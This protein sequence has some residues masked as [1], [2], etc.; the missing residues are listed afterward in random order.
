MNRTRILGIAAA[1]AAAFTI[2]ATAAGVPFVAKGTPLPVSELR[3]WTAYTYWRA[4]PQSAWVQQ[5]LRL[6]GLLGAIVLCG[7]GLAGLVGW[8]A[9]SR[10]IGSREHDARWAT[11]REIEESG[12][13]AGPVRELGAPGL[14]LGEYEG[15][16]VVDKGDAHIAALLP[17]GGGKTRRYMMTNLVNW[18]GSALVL[19]LTEIL[20]ERTAGWRSRIGDVFVFRPLSDRTHCINPLDFLS[21]GNALVTDLQ[22]LIAAV[23]IANEKEEA[24]IWKPS[25]R[26][27]AFGLLYYLIHTPGQ[28]ASF[29][30]L[31][32]LVDHEDGL[33]RFLHWLLEE[34]KA[35]KR[36]LPDLCRVIFS[37]YL[38]CAHETRE[39]YRQNL[40]SALDVFL[41]PSVDAATSTTSPHLDPRKLREHPTT[42][43]LS[44]PVKYL[45]SPLARILA[46]IFDTMH[47]ANLDRSPAQDPDIRVPLWMAADEIG[48]VHLS[49]LKR[50]TAAR[51]FGV[52]WSLLFQDSPQ[53][54]K[55]YGADEAQ[56]LLANADTRLVVATSDM[57]YAK[58]ISE[59]LG[60]T[61]RTVSSKATNKRGGS[62]AET[63]RVEPLIWPHEI[64]ELPEGDMLVIPR[65][66]RAFR[67]KQIDI[68]AEVFA[69]RLDLRTPDLPR[70]P[71]AN[72]D[73]IERVPEEPK[74]EPAPR[75]RAAKPAKDGDFEDEVNKI[76]KVK[77]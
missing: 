46:L 49:S 40:R 73:D 12:M 11:K 52:R 75:R 43:Y 51:N 63:E 65:R 74:E 38:T 4:Y 53:M 64:R 1:V 76:L 33:H 71:E 62:T 19:D 23:V 22:D 66:K 59:A 47:S 77:A 2:G 9:Y 26:S 20:Y 72:H 29:G 8:Q 24:G 36:K 6:G 18:R 68:G 34:H 7:S 56:S 37:G 39:G 58:T 54:R 50:L 48:Q 44:M 25:A 70:A 21:P 14:L 3:P 57:A 69:S 30:R 31:A 61:T 16:W 28:K 5:R 55:N 60:Q 15:R 67:I 42:I 45:G 27:L 13:L 10:S 35:G 17:S 41:N 32:R